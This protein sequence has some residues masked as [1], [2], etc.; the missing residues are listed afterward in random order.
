MAKTIL[1]YDYSNLIKRNYNF[2][3]KVNLLKQLKYITV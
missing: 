3:I 1:F 2:V